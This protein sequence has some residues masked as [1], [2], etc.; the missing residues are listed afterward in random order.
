M[1]SI[2]VYHGYVVL[3]DDI[4]NMN[5]NITGYDWEAKKELVADLVVF[6]D[7]YWTLSIWTSI[8]YVAAVFGGRKLMQHRQKFDLTLTLAAWS[9]AL[10]LFS[11]MG[12]VRM[13]PNMYYALRYQSFYESVC[14]HEWTEIPVVCVWTTL[15]SLSKI[16]E[17]GDTVFI[18]LRKSPLIFLHW[19]HHITVFMYTWY[20]YKERASSGRWFITMN[21]AVHS[22]MYSYYAMKAL[23]F[24]SPNWV[25]MAITLFQLSQMVV[26][27]YIG[28]YI[29]YLHK[30][31]VQCSVTDNNLKASF[32]MYFSYFL[33]FA[34]FFYDTYVNPPR[35]SPK[36]MQNGSASNVIAKSHANGTQSKPISNGQSP[37]HVANGVNGLTKRNGAYANGIHPISDSKKLS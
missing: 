14:S 27:S 11:F 29:Y 36:P 28:I 33:L 34:K 22:V 25:K 12:T 3:R 1:E 5:M 19:Y 7:E 37:S 2:P 15:F 30:D 9:G 16:I 6:Q 32:A 24:R 23:R 26:G 18:V 10:A 17:L 35:R 31:G 20:S 21:Y 4:Y 13:I 8:L